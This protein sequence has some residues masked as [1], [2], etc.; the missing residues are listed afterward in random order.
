MKTHASL[1]IED[2]VAVESRSTNSIRLNQCCIRT[3]YP[4]GSE[5]APEAF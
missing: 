3:G 5:P 2:V 4:K 1:T